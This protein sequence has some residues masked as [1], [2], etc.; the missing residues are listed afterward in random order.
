MDNNVIKDERERRIEEQRKQL[1]EETE[2]KEKQQKARIEKK[3]EGFFVFSVEDF[4][5]AK[6]ETDRCISIKPYRFPGT[7]EEGDA[8]TGCGTTE[9]YHFGRGISDSEGYEGEEE[10]K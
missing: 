1:L 9:L 4:I 8:C 5:Y 7:R 3:K 2:K 10:G 6:A